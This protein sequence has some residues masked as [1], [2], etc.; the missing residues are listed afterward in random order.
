MYCLFNDP[1]TLIPAFLMVPLSVVSKTMFLKDSHLIMDETKDQGHTSEI[2]LLLKVYPIKIECT[3]STKLSCNV[4]DISYSVHVHLSSTQTKSSPRYSIAGVE[5]EVE[6]GKA[7]NIGR[8][9][10]I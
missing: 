10:I 5:A 9:S 1:L 7:S 6:M 2:V 3:V 8:C 4:D